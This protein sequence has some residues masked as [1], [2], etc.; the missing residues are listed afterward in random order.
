[1]GVVGIRDAG[2]QNVEREAVADGGDCT[3]EAG[4][5]I[6]PAFEGGVGRSGF[7]RGLSDAGGV[8]TN[9]DRINVTVNVQGT[10]IPR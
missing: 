4:E 9:R 6:L 7:F 2:D 8:V 1:M 5:Q 3:E 10:Y